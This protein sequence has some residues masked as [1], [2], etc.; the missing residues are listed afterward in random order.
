MTKV[1]TNIVE[2]IPEGIKRPVWSV[3][4]PSFNP[5]EHFLKESINSLLLQDPGSDHMQI[6]FVDDCSTKADLEKFIYDNWKGRVEYHRLPKNVGHSFNFTESVRRARGEFVHLL[7]DDDRVKPGFYTRF[8]SIFRKYKDAGA[9]FCR[10]EYID[11]DGKF[12]F[13]SE[14]EMEETGILDDALV[15]LAQKQRIQYCAMV[16]RRK[17]YEQIGG[18]IPKNIGC[19]DWEMWVR[20]AAHFPIAYEPEALAEYRIHRKSMTLTDMRSGQ[21]MRFLREAACIFTQYLPEDKRE[22]VTLFRQKHYAVYSFNNAKRMYEE[23]N[24]EEGAAAQLSETIILNSEVVYE[25]LDFLSK[26]KIPIHST[27]V[28]V[29]INCQN[30]EDLIEITLRNLANQKVPRYIPWEVVFVDNAST[31]NSV[32]AAAE[33]WKKYRSKTAFRII[34]LNDSAIYEARK[35]AIE[36]AEYNFIIFCNP[37]NLLNINYVETVSKKMMEKINTGAIGGITEQA[38]KQNLPEWFNDS[39]NPSYQIGE[40]F[41]YSGDITWTKGTLWSDGMAIRKE[42]WKSLTDK[43]FISLFGNSAN[44]TGASGI[45][46]EICLAM[47]LTGWKIIYTYDLRLKKFI[48]E[49]ALCWKHLRKIS[50]QSGV[51]SVKLTPYTKIGDKSIRAGKFERFTDIQTGRN[52]RKHIRS[53]Y[54]KLRKFRLWKLLSYHE[55]LEGDEDILK[56]EFLFGVIEEHLKE[57]RSFNK[58]IRLLKKLVRKKEYTYLRS[59]IENRYFR[60]PQYKRKNDARG[61]S[62]VLNYQNSSPYLLKR[63]LEYISIQRINKDFQWEVIVVSNFV[64]EELKKDLKKLWKDSNCTAKLRFETQS[65]LNNN[66]LKYFAKEICTF[67]YMVFLNENDFIGKDYIRIAYKVI[68]KNKSAGMVGG[69]T[70]LISD[71]RPPKWFERNKAFYSIGKIS[72][73]SGDITNNKK[74]LWNSGIVIRKQAIHEAQMYNINLFSENDPGFMNEVPYDPDLA[75]NIKLSGWNILYEHRLILKHFISVKKFTWE[76]LRKLSQYNGIVEMRETAYPNLLNENSNDSHD[77]SWFNKANK[78]FGEIKKYPVKKIFSGVNDFKGDTDVVELEKLKGNFK[79][80]IRNKDKHYKPALEFRAKNKNG[81]ESNSGNDVLFKNEMKAGVSIVICCYNSA[82]TLPLTLKYI[83]TQTVPQNI[84][85]E[86]II[87]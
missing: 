39:I 24:D 75:V 7:H 31:D 37:G 12:M 83:F 40:Q 86:I 47:R 69:Q 8:E 72:E 15:K 20:I 11:D 22:E 71:V 14:P 1:I 57:Y 55:T 77:R 27:G 26:F 78:T 29:I 82:G 80:I 70:E 63:A 5:N 42:A 45:D 38:S 51:K 3:M 79:E 61:I 35:T 32:K 84:P 59:L 17:V 44:K 73:E 33:S 19:E 13:Y 36:S 9:V 4:I 10:Q 21:D 25:N 65:I 64:K 68:S 52:P 23:F 58:K 67:E 34:E 62:V 50:R 30:D 66:K 28:S 85:W 56:I 2:P 16:V 81:H 6:E 48:S 46:S 76:Y 60:F 54:R 41:E 49:S 74:Y 87:V 53:A 43:S 18:Y